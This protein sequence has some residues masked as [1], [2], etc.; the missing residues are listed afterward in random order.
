MAGEGLLFRLT[1]T[2]STEDDVARALEDGPPAGLEDLPL[3]A[4]YAVRFDMTRFG[5]LVAFRDR[6]GQEAHVGDRVAAWLRDD[7][8]PLL[9]A[10][11]EVEGFD[12]L[13][14]AGAATAR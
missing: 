4:W 13:A 8:A 1:A 6:E 3:T 7:L 2:G 10:P 9:G 5:V 11:P 14:A 12:V